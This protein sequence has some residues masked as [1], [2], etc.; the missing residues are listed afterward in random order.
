MYNEFKPVDVSR[1]GVFYN[2]DKSPYVIHTYG[3]CLKF[4]SCKKMEI[5]TRKYNENIQ[6]ISKCFDKVYSIT[7]I[8]FKLTDSIRKIVL[9]YL[10]NH[11]NI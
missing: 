9:N 2:L 1:R 10:Y 5:F 7:G 6:V 3:L 4:S 8:N 11:S